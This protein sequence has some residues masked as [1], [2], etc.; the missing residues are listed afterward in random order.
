GTVLTKNDVV[1]Q[2][3]L[4][5]SLTLSER[6]NIIGLPKSRADVILGS[7]CIVFTAMTVLHADSCTVSIN[8]LR[9]GLLLSE[10]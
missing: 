10:I 3:R 8:G 4:Y 5:S 2:I 9:H 1:R 6:E 7:A